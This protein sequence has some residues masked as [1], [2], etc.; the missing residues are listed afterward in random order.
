MAKMGEDALLSLLQG[1]EEQSANYVH[2]QLSG[3]RE[4]A[5]REYYR[6]PLGNEEEG[7]ST[8]VSSDVQ[9]TV[10]WILPSLL[11]IF[12]ST[13]EAVSFEPQSAEDVKGA[14]QA[15]DA[16]NYVLYK[17][18]N[19]FLILYTALKDALISK[20]CAVMWRKHDD[21]VSKTQ[22]YN[23]LTDDQLAYILQS[24]GEIVAA[25]QEPAI[26][27]QTGMPAVDQMT[28]EPVMM[29][30]ARIKTTEKRS[31]VK[32][33]AFPPEDLLIDRNWTS[34]LLQDCP[35][36]CR[37]MR[38][39][40][41]DLKQ[42][43]YKVS[44]ADMGNADDNGTSADAD[45]RANRSGEGVY[46]E[47]PDD[48]ALIEAWLRIEFVLVDYDGDGIAERR[49][50][51]RLKDKILKNEEVSH[52][53]IATGSPMINPH[54]WDGMSMAE[55][56]SDLMHLKTEIMR[57][58]L[59]SLYLANNPRKKVLTDSSWSPKAN[60]D[61]LLDA[62]PGGLIRQTDLNAVTEDITPFVGGQS[63]P[64][65]EYVDGMRENRT[66][67]TRYNQGIDANSLNKTATGISAIMSASQQRIELMARIFAETLV[68]PICQGV[69]KLLTDGGFEKLSMRLRNEFV[70]LDP[71]EWRDGYDMTI[72]VGLGTGDKQQQA[73]HLQMIFQNQMNL[74]QF[75]LCT[76]KEIYTTQAKMAENAGFKNVGDFFID[77]A[78]KPPEPPQPQQPPPEVQKAQMQIQADQQKFQAQ[79][80]M[81]QQAA[82]ATAQADA[83]RFQAEQQFQMMKMQ[84]E[85]QFER[86]KL[87]QEMEARLTEKQMELAS[88]ER[89]AMMQL[90]SQAMQPPQQPF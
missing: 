64:M 38:V 77:P 26:D 67:V 42:M 56:V 62:R 10:E 31:T 63:F 41:S 73:G 84:A 23:G 36:V 15:T 19:G 59:N 72:N 7:W 37:T 40:M 60:L 83:Q 2:G 88:Q 5:M 18:N 54:R 75:G 81:D 33:D 30:S 20:N 90:Q 74:M 17:Q 76:P 1:K 43:G 32:I 61:D 57:Q 11:K 14:Q 82:Q 70:Q 80:Q 46:S 53:P 51:Y 35:Y 12:T 58:T 79:S 66:G 44:V 13:D 27:Q 55:C 4:K 49:C 16:V 9:D 47:N 25:S 78:S 39:T 6:E 50:I 22:M 52:V 48:D 8:I 69:L 21:E 28:G 34:P 24:G 86:E 87:A 45:Y 29:T 68:K 71:N 3:E 89:I 85:Q 65:L